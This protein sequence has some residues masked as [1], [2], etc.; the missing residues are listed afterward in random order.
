LHSHRELLQE[1]FAGV[2]QRAT[3]IPVAQ[4]RLDQLEREVAA[5]RQNLELFRQQETSNQLRQ[6]IIHSASSRYQV[7]EPAAA[8]LEP[9]YPNRVK[10]SVMGVVLGLILGGAA[11]LIAELLDHSFRKVEEVEDEL[12]LPVLATIPHIDSLR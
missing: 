1:S 3:Q 9:S 12:G 6:D 5:A 7:V 10:I 2:Q 8:P 11:A 4:A